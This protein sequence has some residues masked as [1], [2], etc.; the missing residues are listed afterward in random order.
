M[1]RRR[2]HIGKWKSKAQQ[3]WAFAVERRGK[4]RKGT[5]HKHAVRNPAYKRLPARIGRRRSRRR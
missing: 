3:R 1:A 5:A 2:R 4:L